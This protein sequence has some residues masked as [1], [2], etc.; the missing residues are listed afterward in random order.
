VREDIDA[1]RFAAAVYDVPGQA[2]WQVRLGGRY[3]LATG[4][5]T[6]DSGSIDLLEAHAVV[7][8]EHRELADV[9][10]VV[11]GPDDG[12]GPAQ[13]RSLAADLG[14][15]PVLLGVVPDADLP[16][17]VAGAAAVAYLPT[18]DATGAAALE[19]L[20][21]GVPVVARDLPHLRAVLRDV[22]AYGD[23]VLSIADALVDVLT[24][25]PEPDAGVALAASYS[26]TGG[27]ES[28]DRVVE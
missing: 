1:A 23:T 17:L 21:A 14:T 3:L 24:D 7:V 4:G 6:P 20:A 11:A 25:P 8:Q 12:D 26:S 9:R 13:L 16:A 5:T 10:L 15:D 28:E 19:A 27:A 18:R 22:V 2:A